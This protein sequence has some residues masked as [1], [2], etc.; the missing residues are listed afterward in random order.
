MLASLS[1]LLLLSTVHAK[2]IATLQERQSHQ[3]N[4][5]YD[6]SGSQ[7]QS[8]QDANTLTQFLQSKGVTYNLDYNKLS[9]GIT[10]VNNYFVTKAQQTTTSSNNKGFTNP[11]SGTVQTNSESTSLK[12]GPSYTNASMSAQALLVQAITFSDGDA[13]W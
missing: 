9:A 8:F 13:A 1:A 3:V 5:N 12:G 2:P 6:I 11:N 7:F 10:A 4:L